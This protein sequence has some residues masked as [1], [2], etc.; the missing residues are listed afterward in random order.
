M[1][2]FSIALIAFCFLACLAEVMSVLAHSDEKL[3][4]AEQRSLLGGSGGPNLGCTGRGT[5][6]ACT[7]P[8][9]C[10]NGFWGRCSVGNCTTA[11]LAGCASA[12]GFNICAPQTG[13]SCKQAGGTAACGMYSQPQATGS[14]VSGVWT[15]AGGCDTGVAG[16]AYCMNCL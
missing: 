1:S 5:C 7:P 10:I 4:I 9:G 8:T 13:A 14:Y 12:K 11:G 6:V 16:S 2:R 15:C 3:S